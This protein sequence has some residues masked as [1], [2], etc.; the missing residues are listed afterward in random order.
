MPQKCKF[1]DVHNPQRY[2]K[3]EGALSNVVQTQISNL[4][5]SKVPMYSEIYL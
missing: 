1:L 3:V 4:P 5:I 2:H